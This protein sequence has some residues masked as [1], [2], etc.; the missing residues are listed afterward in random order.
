MIIN[1]LSLC[2][3]RV[4]RGRHE[5]DLAPRVKRGRQKPI[6]LFGGLNGAGK[7]TL[8]LAVRLVLY[9]P[10][11]LGQSMTKKAYDTF[12]SSSIHNS[13][14]SVLQASNSWI[15]MSF[16]Y[17]RDAETHTYHVR[18]SWSKTSNGVKEHLTITDPNN[19]A[20]GLSTEQT[21][22]FLSELIPIGLSELFFFDGEKVAD[23]AEDQTGK[24]LQHAFRKLM[25]L[26]VI[27]RLRSDLS[28]VVREQLRQGSPA[29]LEQEISGLEKQLN[30]LSQNKQNL[31]E[32]TEEL[33]KQLIALS[34]DSGRVQRDLEESGGIWAQTQKQD[35][36]NKINLLASEAAEKSIIGQLLGDA[37]PLLIVKS[38]LSGVIKA[39]D[40]DQNAKQQQQLAE[41]TEARLDTLRKQLLNKLK[42]KDL[43]QAISSA[44]G[45]LQKKNEIKLEACFADLAPGQIEALRHLDKEVLPYSGRKLSAAQQNIAK[46]NQEL[47]QIES[48]LLRAP[49]D[50]S[51]VHDQFI[52]LQDLSE[53]RGDIKRQLKDCLEKIQQT[54]RAEK[55]LIYQLR[56]SV[57][58][59]DALSKESKVDKL[60][61]EARKLL[62]DF[63]KASTQKRLQELEENF[64]ASLHRLNR[65]DDLVTRVQIEPEALNTI[66][67]DVNGQR[68][69]KSDLS[70]GE[71]QIY[72]LAILEALTKTSGRRLPVIID[73]PLGRLDSKHRKNLIERYFPTASH[74]VIILSTDT[75]VDETFFSE[76]SPHISHAFELDFD[77]T[78][79]CSSAKEGYFWKKREHE[80]AA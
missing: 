12:L 25:G 22:A 16:D 35:Q 71:R 28:N 30:E 59:S 78:E 52:A 26:D 53:Q 41:A 11:A 55:E 2:D 50:D 3:F 19:K 63:A 75:E 20:K 77:S 57:A 21:Q 23:L 24:V 33:R 54:L 31:I 58:K 74:Q 17:S 51:I 60:A 76:L 44:F 61:S 9:G 38:K 45:D 1:S 67:Y 47:E 14:T 65:K 56:R 68:I 13:P 48:R 79:K 8:L 37:A 29:E 6:I 32:T 64:A 10:Q 72:A 80:K 66:L 34:A 46:I 40:K 27:D 7:T 36:E 43:E 4:F 62:D 69:S 70:A 49:Q 18:R 42:E 15:E 5:F 73:T 39:L